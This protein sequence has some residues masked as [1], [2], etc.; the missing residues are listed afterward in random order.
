MAL[1]LTSHQFLFRH[2]NEQG[3]TDFYKIIFIP[4]RVLTPA[5]WS[6]CITKNGIT[7]NARFTEQIPTEQLAIELIAETFINDNL[8]N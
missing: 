1:Q 6:I 3:Q 8:F 2:D 4:Q 5:T 7:F